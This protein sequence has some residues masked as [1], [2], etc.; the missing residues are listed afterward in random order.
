MLSTSA[1]HPRCINPGLK[2]QAAVPPHHPPTPRALSLPP[3]PSSDRLFYPRVHHIP[4]PSLLSTCAHRGFIVTNQLLPRGGRS[5]PSRHTPA[6]PPYAIAP[7]RKSHT[8]KKSAGEAPQ[9]TPSS[10]RSAPRHSRSV[11]PP[12]AEQHT[13]TTWQERPADFAA[14]F[15]ADSADAS[16]LHDGLSEPPTTR[17]GTPGLPRPGESNPSSSYS[18][19]PAEASS[20]SSPSSSPSSWLSN[21]SLSLPVK[22]LPAIVG[23]AGI[24]AFLL[25][26]DG[27]TTG[28]YCAPGD[29]HHEDFEGALGMS[30]T[31][32]TSSAGSAGWPASGGGGGGGGG[33]IHAVGAVVS[34]AKDE[35]QER[36]RALLLSRAGDDGTRKDVMA[37]D[38][39]STIRHHP[40]DEPGPL[41]MPVMAAGSLT[42]M[43]PLPEGEAEG[44]PREWREE[45]GAD[46]AEA[47]AEAE[48]EWGP[49][50]YMRGFMSLWRG[51]R[52]ELKQ[53]AREREKRREGEA[54]ARNEGNSN[55]EA[56]EKG[57]EGEEKVAEVN[58]DFP[59]LLEAVADMAESVTVETGVEGAA[60]AA[61][62]LEEVDEEEG[63]VFESDQGG[64]G[65]GRGEGRRGEVESGEEKKKPARASAWALGV[66]IDWRR[67]QKQ[68]EQAQ[69]QKQGSGKAGGEEGATNAETTSGKDQQ[70]QQQQ[71]KVEE[72]KQG[73][74]DPSSEDETALGSGRGAKE[75]GG[76]QA[77]RKAVS[78]DTC[79]S[80]KAFAATASA[81]GGASE[82][83]AGG[84]ESEAAASGKGRSGS[85]NSSS[86][87][88]SSN[89]RGAWVSHTAESLRPFLQQASGEELWRVSLLAWLCE[90]AYSIPRLEVHARPRCPVCLFFYFLLFSFM[91][92]KAFVVGLY[93]SLP[94]STPLHAPF[95]LLCCCLPFFFV[96]CPFFNALPPS[97]EIPPLSLAP[98]APLAPSRPSTCIVALASPSSPPRTS[99]PPLRQKPQLKQPPLLPPLPASPSRKP[100]PPEQPQPQHQQQ[101]QQQPLQAHLTPW[102]RSLQG[103]L[104]SMRFSPLLPST[105][106]CPPLMTPPLPQR[107]RQRQRH[108]HHC[109]QLV[110][111]RSL[112]WWPLLCLPPLPSLAF[113]TPPPP[114]LHQLLALSVLILFRLLYLRHSTLPL[115]LQLP[116]LLL[117]P[118]LRGLKRPLLHLLPRCPHLLLHPIPTPSLCTP[119]LRPSPL[120]PLLPLRPLQP[121]RP[122]RPLRLLLQLPL[123]RLMLRVLLV[124]TPKEEQQAPPLQHLLLQAQQQ[125]QWQEARPLV[126]RAG[127]RRRRRR[128]RQG[129]AGKARAR[130]TYAMTR[131][132]TR[133]TLSSRGQSPWLPGRLT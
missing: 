34:A 54:E 65:E 93:A 9:V 38:D 46:E 82:M 53:D 85:G 121:L 59:P 78:C 75:A 28:D 107:Q 21:V 43:E 8:T 5:G 14:D 52:G 73:V 119:L 4:S 71:L 60:E 36:V 86:S 61:V 57:K 48:G 92:V 26:K 13:S 55:A 87:S 20:A 118:P 123:P 98:L 110:L 67:Q 66:L 44:A 68:E 99:S 120:L 113:P 70:Q 131:R 89:S 108:H 95:C 6:L 18:K 63:A 30:A 100:R 88:S 103:R 130:G 126:Q 12:V 49:R 90:K 25:G 22:S 42:T 129:R 40:R 117:L 72:R 62:W 33:A 128:R 64:E 109:L 101:Q 17:T 23:D 124:L 47:E 35:V 51:M 74:R 37:A 94:L 10:P 2:T 84:A 102:L 133:G 104:P 69:P 127:R 41:S 16:R 106:L 79:S 27:D 122:L 11:S 19:R 81:A 111:L 45:E 32:A 15:A 114:P 31:P 105:L 7:F 80:C 91:R 83:K 116:L 56:A 97:A 77:S 39:F 1:L 125:R 96:S 132:P 24:V 76:K 112:R 58:D 3:S 115:P 50:V 29:E